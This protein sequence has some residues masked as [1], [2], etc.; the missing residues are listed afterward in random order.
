MEEL[1]KIVASVPSEYGAK[2]RD[3][4]GIAGGGKIGDYS[5]CS[6][7]IKGVGCF[8]PDES[9][10]LFIGEI[11]RLDEVEEEH[12]EPTC[13]KSMAAKCISCV[14]FPG[15]DRN[16]NAPERAFGVSNGLD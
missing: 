3:A 1:V 6:F 5:F 7:T 4:V 14:K 9:A 16:S 2:L 10:H 11:G 15:D 12:I 8:K 13:E